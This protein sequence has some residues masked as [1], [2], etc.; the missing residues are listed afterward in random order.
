[1]F[2]HHGGRALSGR[3]GPSCH[4]SC[5]CRCK[6]KCLC[7]CSYNCTLQI[8]PQVRRPGAMLLLLLVTG[9]SA[10][11]VSLSPSKLSSLLAGLLSQSRC[12]CSTCST[13]CRSWNDPDNPWT[14]RPTPFHKDMRRPSEGNRC[15]GSSHTSDS[16]RRSGTARG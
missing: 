13:R 3:R 14:R 15:H 10:V 8:P 16:C 6:C 12:R 4:G 2:C 5:R 7:R 11:F 9:N 1:M